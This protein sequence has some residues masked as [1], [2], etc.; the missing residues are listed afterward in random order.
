MNKPPCATCNGYG[1]VCVCGASLVREYFV[2]KCSVLLNMS[3]K[4]KITWEYLHSST[5]PCP[6][7]N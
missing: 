3:P 1:I 7:C 5:I 4:D 2:K 6:D